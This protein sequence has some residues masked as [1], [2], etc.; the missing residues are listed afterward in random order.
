MHTKNLFE[1]IY[2]I[3]T[4]ILLN[5]DK[6]TYNS[7]N[8]NDPEIFTDN[9]A[10]WTLME[11]FSPDWQ[12]QMLFDVINHTVYQLDVINIQD[13]VHHRWVNS[14]F[15][16]EFDQNSFERMLDP[17][18]HSH[19]GKI[20]YV[21]DDGLDVLVMK[22]HDLVEGVTYDDD[23]DGIIS[24]EL[25]DSE[26]ATIA[27]AAHMRDITINEFINESIRYELDKIDPNWQSELDVLKELTDQEKNIDKLHNDWLV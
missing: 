7:V 19:Y 5:S 20:H 12:I 25:T 26:L 1:E 8:M 16:K 27:R 18:T 10:S 13:S 2:S 17:T 24:L 22:A 21:G 15:K 11:K 3:Y 9:T 23:E 6:I 14:K 4:S